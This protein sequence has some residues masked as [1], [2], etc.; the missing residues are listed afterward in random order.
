MVGVNGGSF[1]G[2]DLPFGGRG[3]SGI[4]REWGVAGFEEFLEIQSVGIGS[5]GS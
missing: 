4:G 2:A 3:Q 1:I 5:V